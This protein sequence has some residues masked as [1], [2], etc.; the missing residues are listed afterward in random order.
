MKRKLKR[1]FIILIVLSVLICGCRFSDTKKANKKSEEGPTITFTDSVGRTVELPEK[2]TR[3]VPSG[4]L[5]QII[6]FAIAPD[7]L[8]GVSGSWSSDAEKYIDE[9]YLELPEIG[10]FYGSDDLNLEE[11]ASLDPQVIIDVGETKQSITEDMDGV[12]EQTGIPTIHI[13]ADTLSM[14]EAFRTLGRLLGQEEQGEKLAQ[15]CDTALSKT[16]E[17]I[18]EAAMSGE[19]VKSVL[20]LTSEN[21][22]NAVAKGS[23][24]SE[25]IDLV[26]DNAAVINN[27]SGKGI[28]NEVGLEK[29]LD[30]DP[31][32][33]I[34][35]PG[36]YYKN[37]SEDDTWQSLQA[38]KN[39][40]YYEVPFGPYN[41]MG[42]PPSVN[43][44][45][46][47]VW[48]TKLLYPDIA[49]YDMWEETS[50]YY[51]LFYH[52]DLTKKQYESLVKNSIGK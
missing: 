4:S 47:M 31:E 44:Y 39:D 27:P 29:I 42:F 16:Q 1:I 12:T 19:G 26:A 28:G 23:F 33:I 10:Q 51:Q 45:L 20:Y 9:I 15:Y 50:E 21:G 40:T 2:I 36:S 14:G 7:S 32:I 52:C 30:W 37:V 3:V 25:I 13:H 6:L 35:A 17:V 46:G 43:R 11:I 18:T 22:E 24:H 38:V 5:A 8:I 49:D 41:W 34:F 48:L